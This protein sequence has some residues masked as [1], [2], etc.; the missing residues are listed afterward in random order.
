MRDCIAPLLAAIVVLGVV[1]L[2]IYCIVGVMFG[3]V[4]YSPGEITGKNYYPSYVVTDLVPYSV[5]DDCT[6]YM[7]EQRTIPERFSV[8]ARTTA[9]PF[10]VFPI[11]VECRE[12]N[13]YTLGDKVTLRIKH[14][15]F[16]DS[17]MYATIQQ[18]ETQ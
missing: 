15:Y 3:P 10:Y 1:L 9:T 4:T 5:G 11:D 2:L 18:L 13:S 8:V 16:T 14:N 17:V 6:I 7:P 12:Y